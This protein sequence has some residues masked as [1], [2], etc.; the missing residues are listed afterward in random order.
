MRMAIVTTFEEETTMTKNA[1]RQKFAGLSVNDDNDQIIIDKALDFIEKYRPKVVGV[2]I[3][4]RNEIDLM[5][6]VLKSHKIIFA[7]PKICTD[8]TMFF[9]SYYPG[10]PLEPNEE[11]VSY[12]EP[13]SD[14]IVTPDLIFVPGLAFDIKGYRLGLGKGHYDKYLASQTPITIGVCRSSNILTRLPSEKHDVKMDHIITED[15]IL[16]LV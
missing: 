3:T 13:V 11:Y 10:A 16:N 14:N 8:G 9:A 12:F 2:Y 1:L 6:I 7:A 15:I 5:P 4:R